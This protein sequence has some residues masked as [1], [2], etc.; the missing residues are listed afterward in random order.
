MPVA[1]ALLLNNVVYN[2]M[3]APFLMRYYSVRENFM[4]RDQALVM[5]SSDWVLDP[6]SS[7]NNVQMMNMAS[8]LGETVP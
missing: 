2:T 4:P 1:K 3:G 5:G 6:L 7:G 8:I